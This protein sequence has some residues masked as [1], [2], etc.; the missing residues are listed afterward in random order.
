MQLDHE[1]ESKLSEAL[2]KLSEI[3]QRLYVREKFV[4]FKKRPG[5][6]NFFPYTIPLFERKLQDKDEI[7]THD[8][9]ALENYFSFL[10]S[11]IIA[12]KL[13][14]NGAF[15]VAITIGEFSIRLEVSKL[16]QLVLTRKRW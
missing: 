5:Y 16:L 9:N 3:F 2:G 1:I 12:E 13:L 6:K 8:K 4:S 7:S 14:S 15:H 11:C 10:E